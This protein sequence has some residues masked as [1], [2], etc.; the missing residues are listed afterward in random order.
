MERGYLRIL[1][2]SELLV[3]GHGAEVEHI[4]TPQMNGQVLRGE[5]GLED[6][7]EAG[8][9]VGTALVE[10]LE[11]RSADGVTAKMMGRESPKK[12]ELHWGMG[13]RATKCAE[14]LW[15]INQRKDGRL[16]LLWRV[17]RQQDIWVRS[18]WRMIRLPARSRLLLKL[19]I[20]KIKKA[21]RNSGWEWTG[22]QLHGSQSSQ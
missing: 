14:L 4:K 12:A 7:Q 11:A 2:I 21:A 15:R 13:R 17:T 5:A 19:V 9:K 16:V 8:L 3:E 1:R 20:I 18:H 10:G 22:R 6:T